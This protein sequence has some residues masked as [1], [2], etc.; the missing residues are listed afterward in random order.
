MFNSYRELHQH[1]YAE[2]IMPIILYNV[3][4]LAPAFL[5]EGCDVNVKE[6]ETEQ[7]KAVI[8]DT[9]PDN[10]SSLKYDIATGTFVA[11]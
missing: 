8:M 10:I 4:S 7:Y 11:K 1:L 5:V 2:I 6:M 3:V 9:V